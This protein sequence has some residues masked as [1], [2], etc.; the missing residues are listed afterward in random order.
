M[1]AP[2]IFVVGNVKGGAGKTT[3][4]MHLIAGLLYHGLRVG[5]ID[6]DYNQLSLTTYI[7]NRE[8]RATK[9]PELS[10]KMPIHSFLGSNME[11]AN[12]DTARDAIGS[13]IGELK[14]KVDA[15]VVDTQ[16]SFCPIAFAACSYADILITPIND[17]FLDIDLLAKVDPDSFKVL[18]L[19]TYSEIVWKQKLIRAQ[20]DGGQIEWVI[21]RNRLSNLDAKNKRAVASVV[22]ELSRRVKCRVALGFSERVIFKELFLQGIT[23]LDMEGIEQSLTMSHIA[24]RQ[25]LRSLFDFLG[26]KKLKRLN[27][28]L[29]QIA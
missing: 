26:M 21:L 15:I 23:L 11:G 16:G 4:S 6:T 25:E 3:C 22:E 28:A 24:A 27:Q 18:N 17:S 10:L 1:S 9:H 20:R 2:Y 12:E 7:K 19:S 5:S 8:I 14:D 13:I 29:R